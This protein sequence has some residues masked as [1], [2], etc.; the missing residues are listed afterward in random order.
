MSLV[1]ITG[2]S[3]SG[4]STVLTE[5]K[6]RGHEAFGTDEEDIAG[7]YDRK[8]GELLTDWRERWEEHR[9]PEWIKKYDWKVSREKIEALA[10]QAKDY[11][12][13]LCGG[14]SNDKEMWD[15][16]SAIVVLSIDQKTLK[17]R[18]ANRTE[19]DYGKAPHEL[20]L[21][22]GWHKGLETSHKKHGH[23]IIDS[24]Q[25]VE[26]VVDEILLLGL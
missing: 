21:I 19:N 4:K 22:L 17:H 12:I 3:G 20:Q 2:I 13:Y 14:S 18:L 11:T 24:T 9:T 25:P 10:A 6:S 23:H 8:T 16:F 26:K 7:F 1:F 5:L 15:L